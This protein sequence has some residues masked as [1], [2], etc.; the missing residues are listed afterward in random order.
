MVVFH[1]ETTERLTGAPGTIEA[2][3]LA[4]VKALDAAFGVHAGRRPHVPVPR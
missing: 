4:E 2:R 3:T 1:D